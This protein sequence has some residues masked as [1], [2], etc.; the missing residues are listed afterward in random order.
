M[1]RS[2]FLA[3]IVA[4][5]FSSCVSGQK[6][7]VEY[8]LQPGHRGF[9]PARIAVLSCQPWPNGAVFDELP[10]SNLGTKENQDFCK[11]FDEFV[12]AGFQNQPF[13]KG[14]TPKVVDKFLET[15]GKADWITQLPKIWSHELDDCLVCK[16]APSFYANSIRPRP[17]WRQWLNELSVMAK[18][19]DAVLIPFLLFGHET[20]LNERG[21]RVARRS[22][23]VMLMLVDTNNGQLIWAGGRDSSISTE[24]LESASTPESLE[25]QPW[26]ELFPRLF[27][28]IMWKDFPGRQEY[29]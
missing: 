10:L 12:V 1:L 4:A 3:F 14:F 19:A 2:I 26:P 16:N 24:K 15:S 11:H 18:N 13:M 29:D 28:N 7:L 9:V 21:L 23:A 17:Q 20:R 27:T 8:G 22:A 6:E 5:S 25:F